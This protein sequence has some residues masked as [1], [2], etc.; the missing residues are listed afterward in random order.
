MLK[1]SDK[2]T[3]K[4]WK[5]I[6]NL[7]NR[8]TQEKQFPNQ[9]DINENSFTKPIDIVNNLNNYFANI[10]LQTGIKKSDAPN[11]PNKIKSISNSFFWLDVTEI[12]IFNIIKSLDSNK[13]N[14]YDNISVKI[15]K[16]INSHVCK[17]ITELINQSYYE[18]K[19][20]DSL[21]L[22]KVIPIFKSGSKSLPGNYRPIS[23]LSN[24]KK[25]IEKVIY[26][27]LYSFFF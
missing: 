24:L 8:K 1:T 20:P 22:A 11:T 2:N 18:S 9:L 27:R 19:Y 3:S 21:K 13:A 14:G 4:I 6:N 12:E 25:K 7:S 16:K 17:V 10:G 23:I 26:N 15:L 5:I